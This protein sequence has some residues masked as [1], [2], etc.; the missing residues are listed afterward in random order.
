[1]SPSRSGTLRLN[2]GTG[3]V[4]HLWSSDDI[5]DLWWETV[6]VCGHGIERIKLK[7]HQESWGALVGTSNRGCYHLADSGSSICH[8][9]HKGD[10]MHLERGTIPRAAYTSRARLSL[11]K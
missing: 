8:C 4:P 11:K 6:S 9:C 5:R 3:S 10:I 2:S 7:F 1:M